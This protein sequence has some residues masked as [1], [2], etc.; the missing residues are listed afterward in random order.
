MKRKTKT[1]ITTEARIK[2]TDWNVA[3]SNKRGYGRNLNRKVLT[4]EITNIPIPAAIYE[5]L[6][7]E[8]RAGNEVRFSANGKEFVRF[9]PVVLADFS[10]MQA[11]A[12]TLT[13]FRDSVYGEMNE[14]ELVTESGKKRDSAAVNEMLKRKESEI[15]SF[16]E[17]LKLL[18]HGVTPD[19]MVTCPNCGYEIRVGK[20]FAA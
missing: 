19:V 1:T 20:K 16:K 3:I 9:Y 13:P 15:A 8:L 12:M 4:K 17:N 6:C 18:K 7:A 10:R 2:C 14:F 5:Q 11:I